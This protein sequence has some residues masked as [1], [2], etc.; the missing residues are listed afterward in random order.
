MGHGKLPKKPLTAEEYYR[1]RDKFHSLTVEKLHAETTRRNI[2]AI[3]ENE[4]GDTLPFSDNASPVLTDL[5]YCDM[6][7]K[8]DPST[9]ILECSKGDC[10]AFLTW[11]CETYKIANKRQKYNS[12]S[13]S[14]RA[15]KMLFA[16]CTGYQMNANAKK[17]VSDVHHLDISSQFKTDLRNF[18]LRP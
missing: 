7:S 6:M 15:F 8:G 18:F 2:V 17:E 4:K 10:M 14:W 16:R 11:I 3:Q 13:V 1:L 5:R 9:A 12:V